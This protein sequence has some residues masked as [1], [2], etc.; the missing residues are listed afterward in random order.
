M[1]QRR[2]HVVHSFIACESNYHVIGS[3]ESAAVIDAARSPT[4]PWCHTGP[5]STPEIFMEPARA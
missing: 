2:P 5:H 3:L 1:S 4:V